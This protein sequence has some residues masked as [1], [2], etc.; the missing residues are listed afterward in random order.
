VIVGIGHVKQVGKSTAAQALCAQLGFHEISFAGPLKE[1]AYK[2]DPLVQSGVPTNI[3]AGRGRLQWVI[4]SLGWDR[5]KE[6]MPEVRRLL[7]NLGV[8]ARETFGEDFWIDQAM[9]Q[10]CLHND[11]VFPDV[12]FLNEFEAVKSENGMLIKI[13]RPGREAAGHISETE[14]LAVPD[15]EWDCIIENRG[16]VLELEAAVVD[17]VQKFKVK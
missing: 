6:Q 10:A 14:L 8:A 4:N 12:R 7:Q 15:D 1:L 9:A 11:V 17:A 5:A 3:G 2:M 13:I 16:T